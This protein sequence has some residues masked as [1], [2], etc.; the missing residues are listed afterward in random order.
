MVSRHRRTALVTGGTGA[1]GR[2]MTLALC[3]AGW[4]VTF[5]AR[6]PA[7]ADALCAE[8]GGAAAALCV[9]LASEAG[10]AAVSAAARTA[11]LA[12]AC[13]GQSP[14]RLLLDT[15]DAAFAGCLAVNLRAAWAL[16]AA[17]T[18]PGIFVA[19]GSLSGEGAPANAAY[20][21]SKGALAGLVAGLAAQGQGRAFLLVPG[22]VPSPMTRSLGAAACETL[23]R[24]TPLGRS[25]HPEEVAEAL[26]YL[27]ENAEAL[28]SGLVLRVSGGLLET[29]R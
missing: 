29:P 4:Q 1:L 9:E 17:Q 26:V 15:D 21:T 3:R 22:F 25:G 8:A 10:L 20:A 7:A 5:T 14:D 19:I 27:A 12:V 23:L 2:A 11:A 28:P 24:V 16:A 13:A 6:D 18:P